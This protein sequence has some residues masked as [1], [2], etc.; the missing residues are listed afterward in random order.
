MLLLLLVESNIIWAEPRRQ[1]RR[2]R[3]LES[4][5]DIRLSGLGCLGSFV[6]RACIT[7]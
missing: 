7:R 4:R 3:V 5:N 6:C 1:C 2:G